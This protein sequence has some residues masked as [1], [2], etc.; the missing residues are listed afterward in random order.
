MDKLSHVKLLKKGAEATLFLAQWQGREVVIKKRLTKKYRPAAL[1]ERI[2]DYRT[3]HEPQLIHEA[4]KAGIPTPFIY[5]VDTTN[6]M[7]VMEYIKGQRLKEKL[8]SATSSRR[9]DLCETLGRLVGRLHKWGI[10]HGDLTTS[11]M[12]L[13]SQERMYLVDFG[14]GEKRADL[15]ARGVDLHLMKRAFQSVHFRWADECFDAALEGYAEIFESGTVQKI[16]KKISEIERR[17]RYVAERVE[18]D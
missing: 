13:G 15:E 12:I 17:G 11:N 6:S 2:R 1:D 7:I 18:K 8:N 9:K 10:V 14:L 5:L 4:K 16:S 3:I